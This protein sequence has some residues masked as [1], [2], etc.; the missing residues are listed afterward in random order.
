MAGTKDEPG[1]LLGT[2]HYY[3]AQGFS[4]FPVKQNKKRKPASDLLLKTG[5]VDKS[6]SQ[7]LG[8]AWASPSSHVRETPLSMLTTRHRGRWPAQISRPSRRLG[9]NLENES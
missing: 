1:T 5:T 2:A 4:V 8:R 7:S 3:V 6:G 9:G